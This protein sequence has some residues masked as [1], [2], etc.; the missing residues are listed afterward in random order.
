[1]VTLSASR[2]FG[3]P[4]LDVQQFSIV[5]AVSRWTLSLWSRRLGGD[6][7]REVTLGLG[8]SRRFG[9]RLSAGMALR[10]LQLAIAGYGS[11]R[12]WCL[13]LGVS[14]AVDSA[15]H[16]GISVQN[17]NNGRLGEGEQ[18]TPQVLRV[19]TAVRPERHLLLCADVV[20]DAADVIAG[21][22]FLGKYPAGIR[23][24]CEGHLHR[25][26]VLRLGFQSRPMRMSAGVGLT[27][28][29]VEVDY[30]CRSHQFLG[31]TQYLT[32]SWH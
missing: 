5:Q 32:V 28:G 23:L 4:E 31:P 22:S 3:L 11:G 12:T 26:L 30:A 10:G 27:A 13:D 7:Y 19:G 29:P 24:G 25:S 14:G 6:L 1:M 20:A 9:E 21:G 16:L 18:S 8:C 2:P 15:W 17:L